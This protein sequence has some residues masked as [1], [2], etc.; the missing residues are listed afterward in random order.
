M[1]DKTTLALVIHFHQPVGNLDS[2][3]HNATDRCYR[4]FLDVLDS[5]PDVR[6]TLHY[7]GCLLEWLEANEPEVPRMLRDMSERGQV[8]LMTGGFYEPVLA[9][10]PARDQVGQIEMLSKHLR[11][12]Y[13]ADPKGLWLTERVWEQD[14]VSSIV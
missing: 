8:E 4:P 10:L 3:V 12:E 13:L 11:D 14:V 1:A 7:S 5:F 9:A 6:M 2:V